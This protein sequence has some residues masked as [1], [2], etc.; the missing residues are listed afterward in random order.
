MV[1]LLARFRYSFN[2]K[3][4]LLVFVLILRQIRGHIAAGYCFGEPVYYWHCRPTHAARTDDTAAA[5]WDDWATAGELLSF[6]KTIE[7]HSSIRQQHILYLISI[8]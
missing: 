6:K 1:I 2:R 8:N 7:V 3:S 4:S 5:F